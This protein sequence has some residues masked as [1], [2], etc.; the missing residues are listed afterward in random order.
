MVDFTACKVACQ[1]YAKAVAP[2]K[3]AA[4]KEAV[5]MAH[6]ICEQLIASE[7]PLSAISMESACKVLSYP[8]AHAV[9]M[10]EGP[11]LALHESFARVLAKFLEL[12]SG[13]E[14][15]ASAGN[16]V[17]DAECTSVAKCA[18][19]LAQSAAQRA[20]ACSRPNGSCTAVMLT[21]LATCIHVVLSA[22]CMLLVSQALTAEQA[23]GLNN[24]L[25]DSVFALCATLEA[26]QTPPLDVAVLA[27]NGTCKPGAFGSVSSALRGRALQAL[28]VPQIRRTF[29][30]SR[31]LEVSMR[32]LQTHARGAV[33]TTNRRQAA[34]LVADIE[35]FLKHWIKAAAILATE[36][37]HGQQVQSLAQDI[38]RAILW[39]CERTTHLDKLKI[40]EKAAD[41]THVR[42]VWES[43]IQLS[44]SLSA[45]ALK[46]RVN[47]R[48]WSDLCTA[49]AAY[50]APCSASS[51]TSVAMFRAPTNP[52]ALFKCNSLLQDSVCSDGLVRLTQA[53]LLQELQQASAATAPVSG[54]VYNAS[55]CLIQQAHTLVEL[56]NSQHK[57]ASSESKE[58]T[59]TSTVAGNATAK[60][61]VKTAACT[62]GK[63][64]QAPGQSKSAFAGLTR[65]LVRSCVDGLNQVAAFAKSA[66]ASASVHVA[67][68]ALMHVSAVLEVLACTVLWTCD[69]KD[70]DG[71]IS[72]V[73]HVLKSVGYCLSQLPLPLFQ[74]ALRVEWE[75]VQFG[76]E[77]HGVGEKLLHAAATA[78]PTL[79]ALAQTKTGAVELSDTTQSLLTLLSTRCSL[80]PSSSGSGKEAESSS[81]SIEARV[82]LEASN[83]L[84]VALRHGSS[85]D[86]TADVGRLVSALAAHTMHALAFGAE[87]GAAHGAATIQA[88][89]A[90]SVLEPQYKA[91]GESAPPM[92][93]LQLVLAHV[94]EFTNRSA[95]IVRCPAA[96]D[97]CVTLIQGLCAS[98]GIMTGAT[99]ETILLHISSQFCW[100]GQLGPAS[101]LGA[102]ILTRIKALSCMLDPA[103]RPTVKAISHARQKGRAKKDPKG[104]H[105]V[106]EEAVAVEDGTLNYQDLQRNAHSLPEYLKHALSLRLWLLLARWSAPTSID[107]FDRNASDGKIGVS[108]YMTNAVCA[109]ESCVESLKK[110][111]QANISTQPAS[112][113]MKGQ[114]QLCVL[115]V[116]ADAAPLY[117]SLGLHGRTADQQAVVQSLQ[118]LASNQMYSNT[119][120]SHAV[121]VAASEL[122]LLCSIQAVCDGT[123]Q[124]DARIYV[125]AEVEWLQKC[126]DVMIIADRALCST[127]IPL[128][129]YSS[130]LAVA[131]EAAWLATAAASRPAASAYVGQFPPS[132]L[133]MRAWI[134]IMCG[135][136]CAYS[137][138]NRQGAV[139]WARRALGAAQTS[140]PSS[141]STSSAHSDTPNV[142]SVGLET[143]LPRLEAVLLLA[144]TQ[145]QAG[146]LEAALACTAEALALARMGSRALRSACAL[147]CLRLW[148]RTGSARLTTAA[149]DVLYQDPHSIEELRDDVT[150]SARDAVRC[151]SWLLQLDL[152]EET[153]LN[154][155]V[156]KQCRANQK[157]PEKLSKMLQ[158]RHTHR[159]WN[160]SALLAAKQNGTKSCKSV[161]MEQGE[162]DEEE[163]EEC[164][165]NRSYLSNMYHTCLPND[166]RAALDTALTPGS[167]AASALATATAAAVLPLAEAVGSF[168][169]LRDL[170]RRVC[171]DTVQNTGSASSSL[172]AWVVGA[173]SCGAAYES[174]VDTADT[175][176]T[177][178]S[179]SCKSS[180]SSGNKRGAQRH[181]P[182][183]A[184]LLRR[185][186]SGEETALQAT[187]EVC[188]N[189]LS[190]FAT[191]SP[192]VPGSGG[193][194]GTV[195]CAPGAV[196]FACLERS[197]GNLLIGR[198]DFSTP[199]VVSLPCGAALRT[200]LHD[201]H[202][203]AA[204]SK[205]TLQET[206]D[207]EV[208]TKWSDHDKRRWW[209]K[210][211][212]HD[213][214]VHTLLARLQTLLGPWRCL[215]STD[216]LTS[217]ST[218]AE[219]ASAAIAAHKR[220][221]LAQVM[222]AAPPGTISAQALQAIEVSADVLCKATRSATSLRLTD[223]EAISG[224][225]TMVAAVMPRLKASAVHQIAA[226]VHA[227]CMSFLN[228]TATESAES[229][230]PLPP[231][232]PSSS[233]ADMQTAT[234]ATS[235]DNALEV[236]SLCSD[237]SSLKVGDLRAQLRA[238][239]ISSDGLKAELVQRLSDASSMSTSDP[240]I[241]APAATTVATG[242]V[243]SST[244]HLLLLLDESLQALPWESMACVR[245]R[246]CSRLPGLALL[247]SM[248]V[249]AYL[250]ASTAA[251][252]LA[253]PSKSISDCGSGG[254][255]SSHEKGTEGEK[256][257]ENAASAAN[258]GLPRSPT[259][260]SS[261]SSKINN[262][263][264]LSPQRH[265]GTSKFQHAN[266]GV[267]GVRLGR[268][269]YVVDPEANL[270]GTRATMQSFLKP[271][272]ERYQWQG[273]VAEVPPEPTVRKAHDEMTLFIFC[274]HGA[275]E[276]V[277]EPHKLRKCY[278]PAALLWGC[279]SGHLAV[280]GVHDPSGAALGYLVNGAPYVL[281]NLWDVTDKVRPYV[282]VC[283]S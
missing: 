234:A 48:P 201:W 230:Q 94:S 15:A 280:R 2:D 101:E 227:A 69:A 192:G 162:R 19:H 149:S 266:A 42:K 181:T 142:L 226:A 79:L 194:A 44:S 203:A 163:E 22:Q 145:E 74:Q 61:P 138:C 223:E 174:S 29:S 8:L 150:A 41:M 33:N 253:I 98:A 9:A 146:N 28:L 210:R 283:M 247:L 90:L 279:S 249:E 186:C 197:N 144:E 3:P 184:S 246:E 180:T 167:G 254:S 248:G 86:A 6:E 118:A 220:A 259:K 129:E 257:K 137:Y 255:G 156:Y 119:G 189:I 64:P 240:S 66:P 224:I 20:A 60:L 25:L 225:S 252:L 36:V 208:V 43:L 11:A 166:I 87:A 191:L 37:S 214:E 24:F 185:A 165:G 34:Q 77:P 159:M 178:S 177:T 91:L 235:T 151:L 12:S 103:G 265:L 59:D 188:F 100:A 218:A 84:L 104:V 195:G 82:V 263:A 196:V 126:N 206:M 16:N 92:L 168:D 152:E 57:E 52:S 113:D 221:S 141:S 154:S 88:E 122:S 45:A 133:A 110:E 70:G 26:P 13:S 1:R 233:S 134:A 243:G 274:G 245:D 49:L 269:W 158:Y 62:P 68:A 236:D 67:A 51:T 72:A 153:Q 179:G 121:H 32:L 213:L 78:L 63:K 155:T 182:A 238:L 160:I 135:K 139:K 39:H 102:S 183:V 18:S 5:Q 96:M 215:L 251:R 50:E 209:K 109:L 262:R 143:A 256:G 4:G 241:P 114:K 172:H 211:D 237:F 89:T 136:T 7:Q 131:A 264:S 107:A 212:E 10:A 175:S 27:V 140:S 282:C 242:A 105:T 157:H 171:A 76:E 58:S 47:V 124:A 112:S 71:D 190:S 173:A 56:C 228:S 281:A 176:S 267:N 81:W 65:G 231:V 111:E 132:A 200:L 115:L 232:P 120:I 123:T 268:S 17:N 229:A 127:N 148:E 117:F 216:Q 53:L 272:G 55:V 23:V 270:P 128:A 219:S 35:D 278:C 222:E 54:S 130:T 116:S 31:A 275:A 205:A 93:L 38:L 169:V 99:G 199:L 202:K 30:A 187:H 73:S 261:S 97:A 276:K 46:V 258:C 80:N 204:D 21:K 170:R 125:P 95:A 106:Q 277:C 198:L 260:S 271:Y 40:A 83:M 239:G 85:L 161:I 108:V 217:S 14:G 273:Y 244:G 75:E 147:P 250:D 164:F 193:C 207:V